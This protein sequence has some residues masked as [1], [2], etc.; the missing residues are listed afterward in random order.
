M[1]EIKKKI[2]ELCEVNNTNQISILTTNLKIEG[3]FEHCLPK[4]KGESD[5]LIT[6][7]E[8][9]VCRIN[10]YCTCENDNCECNDYVCFKYQW[11]NINSD[12]IVAFSL[13]K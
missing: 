12:K 4:C 10:D 1:K 2:I 6:L 8:A 11:I 5:E 13:L 3:N 7:S 9:I